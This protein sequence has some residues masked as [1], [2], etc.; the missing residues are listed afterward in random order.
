MLIC[1]GKGKHLA[2]GEEAKGEEWN[3]QANHR[4][5]AF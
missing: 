3:L 4:N 5:A 2:V 1:T